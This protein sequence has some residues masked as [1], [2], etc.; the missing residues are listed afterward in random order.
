MQK[1]P[2]NLSKCVLTAPELWFLWFFFQLKKWDIFYL[3]ISQNLRGHFTTFESLGGAS[4][5]R[6]KFKGIICNFP[7]IKSIENSYRSSFSKIYFCLIIFSFVSPKLIGNLWFNNLHFYMR[8]K[9]FF[10]R[11]APPLLSKE[12]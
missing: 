4:T 3:P 9:T 7:N 5:P 12:P 8:K 2:S 10:K 6:W 1:Y 11:K